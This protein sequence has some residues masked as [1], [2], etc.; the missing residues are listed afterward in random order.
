M[1]ILNLLRQEY[2]SNT[3]CKEGVVTLR[4]YSNLF[5]YL[6]EHSQQQNHQEPEVIDAKFSAL[7]AFLSCFHLDQIDRLVDI[8][9]HLLPAHAY[10]NFTLQ[11]FTEVVIVA[12]TSN[13]V[14]P[15]N[16]VHV[17]MYNAVIGWLRSTRSLYL[18]H[19]NLDIV[20]IVNNLA[21]FLTCFTSHHVGCLNHPM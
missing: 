1:D 19:T 17:K 5:F 12:L 4:S 6:C 10:Q 16:G 13:I 15:P 11:C 14:S 20:E 21:L 8:L 3:K 2:Y 9:V 18:D 7:H